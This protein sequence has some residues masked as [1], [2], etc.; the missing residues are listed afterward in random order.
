MRFLSGWLD[1]GAACGEG[2]GPEFLNGVRDGV[3]TGP[4]SDEGRH[5]GGPAV[6]DGDA[7]DLDLK[8]VIEI[9]QRSRKQ[10]LRFVFTAEPC[11]V[12]TAADLA[13]ESA[14]QEISTFHGCA[15]VFG[16]LGAFDG[17]QSILFAA[18]SAMCVLNTGRS[19]LI[20][21]TAQ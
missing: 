2:E 16:I 20:V 11:H 4:D 13:E 21:T 1:R 10:L 12:P 17:A 19:A 5:D 14:I 3:L 15:C 7:Q 9:G 6:I 18:W 8:P